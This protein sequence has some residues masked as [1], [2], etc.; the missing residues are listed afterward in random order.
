MPPSEQEDSLDTW[1]EKA[2]LE[3]IELSGK[4][5]SKISLIDLCNKAEH[6][7]GLPASKRRRLVQIRFDN[8]K[9]KSIQK[10]AAYLDRLE[11]AHG[12]ATVRELRR[13]VINPLPPAEEETASPPDNVAAS[14]EGET[15][16]PS[17]DESFVEV[18]MESAFQ[19]L[20]LKSPPK[21]HGYFA[22]PPRPARTTSMMSPDGVGTP[23]PWTNSGDSTTS[24]SGLH[25]GSKSNPYVINVDVQH[26]ER[27]REFDIDFVETM[28]HGDYIRKGFHIRV[29]AGVLDVDLWEARMY[30]GEGYKNRAILVKGP[31]RTSWMDNLESYH[32]K[33]KCEL[34]RVAHIAT[35]N[36]I[37]NNKD[38][39]VAYWLLVFP[40]Y[41]TLNNEIFS[42][43]PDNIESGSIGLKEKIDGVTFG[44]SI[45]FWKIAQRFGG[46]RVDCKKKTKVKDLFD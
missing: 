21:P 26:P 36:D 39:Q 44:T 5:R 23:P 12:T 40:A 29:N 34:T 9:R 30:Q 43:D 11:I 22:T 8:L 4:I 24:T 45:V 17:S 10:W 33:G 15:S 32:R 6:I 27:N 37:S 25:E 28:K 19:K 16:S 31:S 2:L 20:S 46:R 13:L 35:H 42:G 7:F 14:S 3:Q 1:I 38:R 41:M 18:Q